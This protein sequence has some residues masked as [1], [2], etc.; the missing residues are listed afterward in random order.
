MLDGYIDI[1][2]DLRRQMRVNSFILS[3]VLLTTYHAVD[4]LNKGDI[5]LQHNFDGPVEQ[6]VWNPFLG[7]LVQLVITDRGNQA[8]RIQRSLITAGSTWVIIPLPAFTL[9][10]YK[11][12]IQANVKAENISAP[13]NS[14]NGIKIMLHTTGPNSDNYPQQNLPQGTFDWRTADYVASV[15][16]D[17][18]QATL[19]LG[20]ELVTGTVWFDDLKVTIYSKARP[21]PPRPP[22][23]GLPY[24][25]HNLTRLR[26][27]M[28]GTSLKEKD[29]KDFGSWNANHVR[30]QLMWNG[31]PHSSADNGDIPAYEAWL[32]SALKLL[33]SMIPVCRQLGIHILIDL[34]TTP[35]GRNEA[36]ECNIFR[37]KRFQDTFLLLWK[38]L[39]DAIEMNQLFGVMIYLMNLSKE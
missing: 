39:L 29:F 14:W 10:G 24:K 28:I 31:F 25:G 3:L 37:E 26:G 6:A 16:I 4:A 19:R 20:L 34:H 30:W 12:R 23:P 18:Q 5:V 22:P 17:T 8:L 32:E 7:P 13:P 9:R 27:A 1:L 15:P 2:V 36:K 11:I 38:R 21:P 35:G 33:D